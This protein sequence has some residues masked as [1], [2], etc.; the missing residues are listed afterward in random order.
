MIEEAVGADEADGVG[1]VADGSAVADGGAVAVET[2]AAEGTA[3]G[4]DA[5]AGAAPALP[6]GAPQPMQ[7]S[8]TAITVAPV[9]SALASAFMSTSL[10]S[11]C[12]AT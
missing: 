4:V 12:W 10:I 1:T 9:T 7:T 5:E 6:P 8:A 3:A 2:A 11:G